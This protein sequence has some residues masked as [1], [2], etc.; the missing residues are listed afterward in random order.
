MHLDLHCYLFISN[1]G[2]PIDANP[3]I[4]AP[5]RQ[6]A[7]FA[8]VVAPAVRL[9]IKLQISSR[10]TIVSGVRTSSV[11]ADRVSPGDRIVEIDGEDVSRMNVWEITTIMAR[12]AESERVL[13]LL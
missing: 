13:S 11:L 1:D 6:P 7:V 3:S 10:G 8:V 4:S 9:G 12:K 5:A 2:R